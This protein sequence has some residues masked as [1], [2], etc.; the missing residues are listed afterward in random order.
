MIARV[1]V[2]LLVLSLAL[3]GCSGGKK[4]APPEIILPDNITTEDI[5]RLS[6]LASKYPTSF[7]FAGQETLEPI[8]HWINE[9]L[10]AGTGA[11]GV[12]LP[13]DD[14]SVDYGGEIVAFD[15]SDKVP[16]GQPAEVR[17]TL[18]WW[19]DPGRSADLD[20]WVDMP[21]DGGALDSGRF[22]ESMNWNII[23]KIRVV[24]SVHLEGQPFMVGVQVNNG[25]IF[26]PQ[27]TVPFSLK[28]EFYFVKD[29]LPPGAPYAINVPDNATLLIVNT[30]RVIGDEHVDLDF[31]VVGPDD[32]RVH[33]MH[34]NDIASETTSI[35]VR[36]GG[37]YVV[38]AQRMH[39]GF[40]R[41]ETDVPNEDFVARQLE[42]TVDERML[43]EATPS[44]GTYAEQSAASSNT[45]GTQGT[46]DVGPGFPLD[47][48]PVLTSTA[49]SVDAAINITGPNGWLTTGFARGSYS[50]ERGRVGAV[51]II[52]TVEG[53]ITMSEGTYGYG[54]VS[55]SAG[56]SLGVKI[57]SYTR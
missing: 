11:T 48:I 33:S 13:T 30:E 34:W 3:S 21:G 49:A 28:V 14:G 46:F 40:L 16:A 7:S 27:S 5:D 4:K 29:V 31:V 43:L 9:T 47:V 41:F 50:D 56:T 35:P 57:L 44:P 1:A 42:L 38:Y 52:R 10:D 20:I 22:D 25:R 39:G 26:D 15:V 2:V 36:G 45:F 23:N 32:K 37:E 6:T 24:D 19:G 12:E 51:P 55:N 53:R 17:I 54:I 8:T 18:K